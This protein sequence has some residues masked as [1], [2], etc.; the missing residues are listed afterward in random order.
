MITNAE[1]KKK[2][3]NI[4]LQN[5][6]RYITGHHFTHIHMSINLKYRA[7]V[8]LPSSKSGSMLPSCQDTLRMCFIRGLLFCFHEKKQRCRLF[9][10]CIPGHYDYGGFK[11]GGSD[12]TGSLFATN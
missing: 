9:N 1:N 3:R 2:K 4:K 12:V 7:Q 11:G 6:E 5:S 10:M 8:V